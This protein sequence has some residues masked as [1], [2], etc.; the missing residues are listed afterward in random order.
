MRLS[1]IDGYRPNPSS[2]ADRALVHVAAA[3]EG[4]L[5][6]VKREPADP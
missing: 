4:G 5:L 2:A 6:A 1:A 3:G